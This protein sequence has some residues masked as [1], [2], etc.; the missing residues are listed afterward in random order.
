M[1]KFGWELEFISWINRDGSG[2]SKVSKGRIELLKNERF[3]LH[4][5]S[6]THDT[7][8]IHGFNSHVVKIKKKAKQIK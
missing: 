1:K 3:K 8:I 4:R 6:L 5:L 7:Y 2:V